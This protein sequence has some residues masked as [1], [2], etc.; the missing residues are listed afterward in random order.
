MSRRLM[1][2][3]MTLVTAASLLVSPIYGQD[4]PAAQ[5][6]QSQ[7]PTQAG[8]PPQYQPPAATEGLPPAPARSL[9]LTSGPH[10]SKGNSW[11]PTLLAPYTPMRIPKPVVT[12]AP[13]ID[14]L[15]SNSKL[16]LSLEDAISLGLENNLAIA[17]ERYVP[18]LDE[19]SL[20]LAKSGANGK[21]VFDPSVTSSLTTEE[22]T[23]PINNPFFAGVSAGS[24][25]AA[26]IDHSFVANFG[27][28][29]GFQPGTQLQVTFDN[30]RSSSTSVFNSFN[31][32]VQSTLQV[33]LTQPLLNGFGRTINNRYI[34]EAKNTV[35]V[36]ESQF[37]QQVITTVTQV[38]TD[39][40]E[41]VYARENVKVE[42]VAVAADQQLYENNKKQLEIGTMAPLDVIT[43]QS[44]LA[45]DQQALVQAQTT[46]LLDET[47][48]LVA[49][50]KN[51]LAASL[52]G[53][54]I[55][56]TTTIFSP[57]SESI[58]LEDAVK[59]AWQKRP[60][61]Q[62]AELNLKN[63]GVEV[64]A[65]KNLLLPTLNLFGLY[66]TTGLDGVRIPLLPNGLITA[67][68]PVFATSGTFPDTTT[69]IGFVGSTDVAPG[70]PI[71]AGLTDAWDQFI[72][73]KFPTF[74]GGL[75]L[76][77][78]IRNRAA[79]AAN[80]TAQLNERQ[81]EVQYLQT[82]NTIVLNVR[83]TLITLEQDRAAIAAAEQAR[84]YAQQSYDDEVKKL[85]LGTSTAFTV[86]QKQQLLT[87]AQG[88]EL[89]DRINLIEA[90]L[91]F[92]QAMGRT[93]EVNSITLA[94]AIKGGISRSPNIPGTP[95]VDRRAGH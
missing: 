49:I 80:A 40:W 67:T 44:Q 74:E 69:P 65:T 34:I 75:N 8:P 55:I 51:P 26:I 78:P 64:K 14:Q 12:N 50:T 45:T 33:Q 62:Q 87:T 48:L 72:H 41:L 73:S 10:Y 37:A 4:Q 18:W 46:K 82:Q 1:H 77:L 95:D 63:A 24:G 32:S 89:R 43:A 30:T 58:A 59:E 93:L 11:F 61:L 86:V 7:T 88:V 31:P 47:T 81:Q 2:A 53:V 16:M 35:K 92:N 57:A 20:L 19:A 79:Q 22:Q 71:P 90:E 56:P 5:S 28:T 3:A 29:Q 25:V 27:Y 68:T 70:T 38:A 39:Y 9:G 85:Q 91:N 52:R 76:T 13:R 94:D 60:E 54:E 21:T 66:S 17:V 42:Q 6:G 23:I 15:I 84:I 83:Q 36:G